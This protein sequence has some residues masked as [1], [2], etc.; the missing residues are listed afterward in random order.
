MDVELSTGISYL[1]A[2]RRYRA[3]VFMSR[4]SDGWL[5]AKPYQAGDT[6]AVETVGENFNKRPAHKGAV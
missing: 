6:Q 5:L 1:R 2:R 4:S 3:P